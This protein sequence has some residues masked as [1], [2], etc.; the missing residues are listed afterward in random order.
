[1]SY[2]LSLPQTIHRDQWAKMADNKSQPKLVRVFGLYSSRRRRMCAAVWVP[3][4]ATP[5]LKMAIQINTNKRRLY[6]CIHSHN[7]FITNFSGTN[8][9]RHSRVGYFPRRRFNPTRCNRCFR[10]WSMCCLSWLGRRDSDSRKHPQVGHLANHPTLFYQQQLNYQ[11]PLPNST[12]TTSSYSSNGDL[13]TIDRV[14]VVM[15]RLRNNRKH[16]RLLINATAA[17]LKASLVFGGI[18]RRRT[19]TRV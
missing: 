10:H 2:N 7:P 5:T 12:A 13:Q 4:L 1:M 14:Q 8:G 6:L 3:L 18:R 15:H 11:Q 16:T 19:R 17:L 9:S